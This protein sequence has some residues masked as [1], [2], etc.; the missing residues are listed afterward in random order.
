[1]L[2]MRESDLSIKLKMKLQELD[3][4]LRAK[5]NEMNSKRDLMIKRHITTLF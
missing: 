3:F 5:D 2:R 1:M 4:K